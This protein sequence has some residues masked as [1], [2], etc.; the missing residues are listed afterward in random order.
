M[1]TTIPT[2]TAYPDGAVVRVVADDGGVLSFNMNEEPTPGGSA[3]TVTITDT[4]GVGFVA[5]AGVLAAWGR[6]E[7]PRGAVARAV[8]RRTASPT[9]S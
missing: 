5:V 1:G 2:S 4:G 7:T 9:S 8:R 6:A 3:T